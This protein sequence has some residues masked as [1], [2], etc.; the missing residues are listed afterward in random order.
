MEVIADL[1]MHSKYSRAT[2]KNL[3]FENIEKYAKIKVLSLVGTGDFTH[4]KW[5]QEIKTKLT[6]KDDSGIYQTKTGFPFLLQSEISLMYKWNGK[7]R[8]IHNVI[9]APNLKVVDQITEYLLTKGRVDYDGRPIFGIPCPE[10]TEALMQISK[11]IEIIPAHTWTPHFGVFGSEGG[12]NTLKE[13]FEEQV[14][15][16]HGIETGISA[17]PPFFW[18]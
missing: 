11:D 13:C 5:I 10:F 4:P 7:G 2:S 17:N 12:F 3:I 18:L 9:L 14:K 6:E 1:H 8:K 16:I 15:N